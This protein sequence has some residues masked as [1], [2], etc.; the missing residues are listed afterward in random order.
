MKFF[1][2]LKNV[3]PTALCVIGAADISYGV[4]LINLP[5]GIIT[6]GVILVALGV[7]L[8]RGGGD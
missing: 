8:I 3:F 5:A 1:K 2:W 7:I 6:T 4:I